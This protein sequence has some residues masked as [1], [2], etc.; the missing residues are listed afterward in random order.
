MALGSQMAPSTLGPGA[1][2]GGGSVYPMNEL[3]SAH[4]V[5]P[6]ILACLCMEAAS[7]EPG[8]WTCFRP[9]GLCRVGAADATKGEPVRWWSQ[10]QLPLGY[11]RAAL[12]SP[13]ATL[14]SCCFSLG[15]PTS[16]L[17]FYPAQSREC[18]CPSPAW[19]EG[20]ECFSRGCQEWAVG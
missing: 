14:S 8:L 20:G 18:P 4:P 2:A 3:G 17:F 19:R 9:G 16:L 1:G 7:R 12:P 15:A 13:W 10:Q 5:V 11:S 6:F